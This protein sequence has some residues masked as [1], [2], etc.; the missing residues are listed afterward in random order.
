MIA[1][2][3]RWLEMK[4]AD[5]LGKIEDGNIGTLVAL[6]ITTSVSEPRKL[7]LRP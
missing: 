7:C 3:L 5:I 1:R 4:E 6:E 2:L